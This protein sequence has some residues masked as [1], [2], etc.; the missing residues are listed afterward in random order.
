MERN[1]L[2]AVCNTQIFAFEEF[3]NFDPQI[4][5]KQVQ[6]E[7]MEIIIAYGQYV[8]FIELKDELESKQENFDRNEI[9]N[10]LNNRSANMQFEYT[11][12]SPYRIRKE[13]FD[14]KLAYASWDASQTLKKLIEN[15]PSFCENKITTFP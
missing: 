12:K 6:N 14:V 8:M 11:E 5:E 13:P 1:Q 15:S 10:W 2:L 9:L 7:N 3:K 4:G